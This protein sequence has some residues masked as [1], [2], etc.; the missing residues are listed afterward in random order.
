MSWGTC[1]SGS[2]NIHMGYP[3]LM[4]DGRLYGDWNA[5]C[6]NNNALKAKEGITNNYNYRQ[7]LIN[8]GSKVMLE[9]AKASC[10]NCCAC[11]ENFN[12]TPRK[13]D[14]YIFKS[15]SDKTVP[16]GYEHSDLKNMYLS[17]KDLSN[18]LNAPILTQSQYLAQNISNYN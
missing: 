11:F 6:K 12:K 18:R 10:D 14:K 9:N 5:A 8:N 16:F 2:N 4:S 13:N 1:Y 15:C 17:S 7:Y 3:A